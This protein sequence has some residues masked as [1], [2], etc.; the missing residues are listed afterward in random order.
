MPVSTTDS[1]SK[2]LLMPS[3]LFLCVSAHKGQPYG[4]GGCPGP[5]GDHSQHAS[6]RGLSVREPVSTG[7]SDGVCTDGECSSVL[8]TSQEYP[9]HENIHMHSYQ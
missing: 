5:V 1:D 4:S 9:T 3:D 8:K 6:L 2:A 7:P